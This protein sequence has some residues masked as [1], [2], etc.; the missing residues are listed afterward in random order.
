[1]STSRNKPMTREEIAAIEVGRTEISPRAA[2]C[3]VLLFLGFIGVAPLLQLGLDL[4][5][6]PRRLPQPLSVF[7]IPG[8]ACAVFQRTGGTLVRRI[9]RA[10]A[11]ALERMKA[12]EDELD[13]GSLLTAVL[14]GPTQEFLLRFL[15]KGNENVYPGRGRWLFYRPGIDSVSG[16]GFLD[17]DQLAKRRDSGNEYTPSPHPDPRPA[18]LD[19]HRRLEARGIRLVLV[20]VPSKVTI[21]PERFTARFGE[22]GS[23]PRNPS[24]RQFVREMADAGVLVFDPAAFLLEGAVERRESQ[25]LEA[26][27]HWTPA[28]MTRAARELARFLRCRI[29]L[30]A[31][32]VQYRRV[33]KTVSN[34]GDIARMLQLPPGRQPYPPQ[35][36]AVQSVVTGAN[37]LWRP[38]RD[39][40]ILLLGDS[41][42]NI[43]SVSEMGWGEAGGFAEQLGYS[44]GLPLDRV[45]RNAGGAFATR[46]MLSRELARGRDRLAGKRVVVWEFAER[47]LAVGD[48]QFLSLT[49]GRPRPRRFVTP[50]PGQSMIVEGI[51][52]EV[53]AVPLPGT[54]PYKD[55]IEAV[56]LVELR[57]T[58]GPIPEGEALVYLWSMRD[59][60][61]TPA[62]H[63]REGERVR[64][65]LRA[66]SDVAERLDSINRS[67]I[68]NDDLAL[69]VPCWG[70]EA[71]R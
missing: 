52:R 49:L 50:N 56:H 26:D 48:W 8:E 4:R 45:T 41:F 12:F 38:R 43:Y 40:S 59:G 64:L 36:V 70:E 46:R 63:Y 47:E 61:W 1:M 28:A 39:A 9:L 20:P 42:T 21:H 54:V 27:S 58:A 62:A 55:H 31:P 66:W 67:E 15:G 33:A 6:E 19:F 23:A 2:R 30:P 68:D 14:L 17:P 18:I 37:T 44:L 5:R 3:F 7:A 13:K 25:Y 57:T 71:R 29:D 60:R 11:A 51:V 16:P 22:N 24:F 65:R 35:S 32:S 10:N 53:S 69:E 34:L